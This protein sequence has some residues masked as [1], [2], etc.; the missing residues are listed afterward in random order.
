MYAFSYTQLLKV[1]I[2]P[3]RLTSVITSTYLY[4]LIVR[5]PIQDRVA[6][7]NRLTCK[8]KLDLADLQTAPHQTQPPQSTTIINLIAKAK[9]IACLH[10]GHGGPLKASKGIQFLEAIKKPK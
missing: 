3:I 7:I 10:H 8:C 1:S 4:T 5:E 6:F 9:T 2:Q